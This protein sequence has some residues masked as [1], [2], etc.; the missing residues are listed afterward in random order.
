MK[1]NINED[2]CDFK[3][4]S[5]KDVKEI[6]SV[7]H[8]F[9]DNLT[10]AK[11]LYLENDDSNKV[12][13]IGFRTPPNSSKGICHIIEHSV[14]SGSKKYK[15][16]EPFMDLLKGSLQTFLNAMTFSDKTIYPVASR[17]DK[18]F[19]NLMDVY[20]DSVFNPLIAEN[21]KIFMQEGWH[22]EILD[23]DSPITYTGVV[24]NEMKG[25][26]STP[27]SSLYYEMNKFLFKDTPYGFESG[28]EPYEIPDLTYDEFLDYYKKYYH[29][30][31]SYIFLYGKMDIREKLEHLRSYL[32]NYKK[33]SINSLPTIQKPFENELICNAKYSISPEESDENKNYLLYNAVT[34][35]KKNIK[36]NYINEILMEALINSQSSPLKI[37]LLSENFCEDVFA[38]SSDGRQSTF[39]VSAANC[40]KNYLEKFKNIIDDELKN[41]VKKGIDKD[42]I[43]STINKIEYSLK[44]CSNYPTR[45]VI[46][47]INA[48]NSW[49]YDEDPVYSIE[50]EEVFNE[51]RSDVDKGV[52]EK[53]IE[54]KILNN[55]HKIIMDLEPKKGLNED[56]DREVEEKLNEYKK[57]LSEKE[58]EDLIKESKELIDYQTREDSLEDKATIPTLKLSDISPESIK[59]N[60]KKEKNLNCDFILND[61]FTSH[62]DYIDL[63][64]DLN[65]FNLEELPFI[66]FICE[67]MGGVDT[68]NFKYPELEKEIFLSTGG[69]TADIL[70]MPIFNTKD[71]FTL[72]LVLSAKT[73]KENLNKMKELI[74][75]LILN[76][77]FSSKQRINEILQ[78]VKSNYELKI[79]QSG[80]TFAMMRLKSYYSVNGN[81]N[82]FI[83]GIEY[84]KFINNL[85]KEIEKDFSKVLVKIENI[86]KKMFLKEDL[87]VNITAEK[88][89][90]DEIIKTSVNIINELNDEKYEKVEICEKN[91]NKNEGFS[92]SSNVQ[93]VITGGNY[94]DKGYKLDSKM[95][96]LSNLLSKTYLHNMIRARGGAYGCGISFSKNGDVLF[97]SYRDPNLKETLDVYKKTGEFLRNLDISKEELENFII[98][99]VNNFDPPTT[100]FLKG[101]FAL[102]MHISGYSEEDIKNELK[103]ALSTS[104]EDLKNFAKLIDE[105]LAENLICVIGNSKVVNENK[106]LF[107]EV[108]GIK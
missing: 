87:I 22:Y 61:Y 107:N 54:D 50:F 90:F 78:M 14:L 6:N 72:K 57:S 71:K 93:Y 26:F 5:S 83:S 64:F 49:L 18:D 60:N 41:F 32:K 58:L 81:I 74:L 10:G 35:E 89:D 40:P 92:T 76:S 65:H 82:D 21:K 37:K 16:K 95:T 77:D 104:V 31:N 9:N 96:V 39:G 69:I 15:T 34:C 45:G 94:F 2:I 25:A 29:P 47:F 27:I 108:K 7:C 79:L 70:C 98:G 1:I 48:L 67:L 97:M 91:K 13:G 12:F 59:F 63:A 23:K 36:E 88:S 20:L 38:I 56:K 55:P 102:T 17:N 30:S 46:Y 43:L 24:Y 28:G 4:V 51:L 73:T 80:S 68:K 85:E 44:E 75:E 3:L 100:P 53:F 42:L 84:F 66:A 11:L 101:K 52:F 106:E 86:Y 62:I 103:N 99:T 19:Y 33:E 8:I 105:I